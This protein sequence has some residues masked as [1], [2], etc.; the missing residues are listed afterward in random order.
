MFG[1][2]FNPVTWKLPMS[3]NNKTN[4]FTRCR[5]IMCW[6]ISE[7]A[8]T[9]LQAMQRF[10]RNIIVRDMVRLSTW[11][12]MKCSRNW[13]KQSIKKTDKMLTR[14]SLRKHNPQ[15][16]HI[17]HRLNPCTTTWFAV[18]EFFWIQ[19]LVTV[20]HSKQHGNWDAFICTFWLCANSCSVWWAVAASREAN[21]NWQLKYTSY[22]LICII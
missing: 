19:Y 2:S 17:F 5:S 3:T 4:N 10:C 13:T 6:S 22:I 12:A 1:F 21:F 7:A 9:R 16:R 14:A 20:P 8:T 11:M 15:S 18:T